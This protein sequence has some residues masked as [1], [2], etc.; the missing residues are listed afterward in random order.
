MF[1]LLV[2]G[3]LPHRMAVKYNIAVRTTLHDMLSCIVSCGIVK[4]VVTNLMDNLK[5][6][7]IHTNKVYSVR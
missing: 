6:E 5:T 2:I 7:I 1:G 4:M 3:S